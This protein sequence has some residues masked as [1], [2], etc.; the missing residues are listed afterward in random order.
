[1][2]Y[3]GRSINAKPTYIVSEVCS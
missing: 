1:M 3:P 2:Q